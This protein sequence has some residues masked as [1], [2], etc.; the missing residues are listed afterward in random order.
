MKPVLKFGLSRGRDRMLIISDRWNEL[1]K[2]QKGECFFFNSSAFW[3]CVLFVFVLQN[4][5]M[6]GISSFQTAILNYLPVVLL[7]TSCRNP[8][9]G[10]FTSRRQ[11]TILLNLRVTSGTVCMRYWQKVRSRWLDIDLVPYCV[12]MAEKKSSGSN[13]VNPEQA[14]QGHLACSGSQLEHRIRFVLPARQFSRI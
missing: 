3:R 6:W 10:H 7:F 8:K 9:A 12:L 4:S 1:V 2:P 14:R 11:T 5:L 13:A